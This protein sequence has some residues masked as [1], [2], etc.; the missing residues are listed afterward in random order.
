MAS[1]SNCKMCVRGQA[2]EVSH[3]REIKD[4]ILGQLR[5]KPYFKNTCWDVYKLK[6]SGV[7]KHHSLFFTPHS[8]AGN[9]FTAEI[10]VVD[11]EVV[12]CAAH[13]E[14]VPLSNFSHLGTVNRSIADIIDVAVNC[15]QWFGS[16]HGILNNCQNYVKNLSSELD[17]TTEWTDVGITAATAATAATVMITAAAFLAGAVAGGVVYSRNKKRDK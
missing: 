4:M 9:G 3:L 7:F 12:F 8:S 2:I 1:C 11:G 6:P 16:F 13:Y 10:R 5:D 15:S 17:L 14:D